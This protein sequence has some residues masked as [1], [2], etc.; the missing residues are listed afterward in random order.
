VV[1]ANAPGSGPHKWAGAPSAVRHDDGSFTLAY[2]VRDNG[3]GV[4]I[5]RSADGEHFETVVS[6]PSSQ[7]GVGMTERPALIQMGDGSWRMYVSCGNEIGHHWWISLLEAETLEG[8]AHAPLRTIFPGDA[9]TWVKDPIVH[10]YGG[11]WHA[12]ICC[13]LADIPGAEDRMN[14]A[15]ATSEDGLD[16]MWHGTVLEG[17]PGYWDSRGARMTVVLEDGRAAYDGR[18]SKEENWFERTG[19]ANQEPGSESFTAIGNAPVAGHRYLEAVPVPGG[20][21]IFYEALLPDESH[22]LRTELILD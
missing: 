1:V 9:V 2:R 7:M 22:E 17:R 11:K 3:D 18:A 14:T 4:V 21:R 8:L 13:H 10:R 12:W 19:L 20:F 16:W 15:Y 6:I 5:A